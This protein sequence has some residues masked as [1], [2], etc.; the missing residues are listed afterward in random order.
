MELFI[1]WHTWVRVFL[2]SP[3]IT[4]PGF[5]SMVNPPERLDWGHK[6]WW[7]RIQQSAPIFR[8]TLRDCRLKF[9]LLLRKHLFCVILAFCG[10]ICE[11]LPYNSTVAWVC[12]CLRGPWK[13]QSLLSSGMIRPWSAGWTLMVCSSWSPHA[14]VR[15]GEWSLRRAY[16]IYP[17]V[18]KSKTLA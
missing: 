7:S 16:V 15:Q 5:L 17:R 14:L 13:C 18:S 6:G 2:L 10:N 4:G 12:D 1:V 9:P 11:A 3:H 8:Q